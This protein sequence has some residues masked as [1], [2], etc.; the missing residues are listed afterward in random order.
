MTF[1]DFCANVASTFSKKSPAS[2]TAIGTYTYI[3]YMFFLYSAITLGSPT[4]LRA[5]LA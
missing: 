1:P 5:E 2:C 3:I 4:G